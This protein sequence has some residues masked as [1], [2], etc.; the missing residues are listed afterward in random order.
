M[1]DRYLNTEEEQETTI[2]MGG[3]SFRIRFYPF[4]NL[5]YMDLSDGEESVFNGK[6]VMANQWILPN[7]IAE[8]VGNMRF[9]TYASD[10]E[11]YVW[12][13]GFN[14]KFRLVSYTPD[15]IAEI[16]AAKEE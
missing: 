12:W 6:R 3:R 11:D 2:S 13:A 5:M 16:E 4:R 8:D 1:T 10:S 14:T 15:E 9:E 7:Y